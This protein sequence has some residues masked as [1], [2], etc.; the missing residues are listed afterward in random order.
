VAVRFPLAF[1]ARRCIMKR[2]KRTYYIEAWTEWGDSKTFYSE[3]QAVR[4]LAK[5]T[6]NGG[7]GWYLV[8]EHPYM[9]NDCACAQYVDDYN[10]QVVNGKIERY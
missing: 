10:P 1:C 9:E 2:M 8:H 4:W 5:M 6:R 3:N 7:S